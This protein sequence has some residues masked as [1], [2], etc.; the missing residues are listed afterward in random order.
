MAPR[1]GSCPRA[2]PTPPPDATSRLPVLLAGDIGGT[3]TR[4]ALYEETS[5]AREVERVGA[6]RVVGRDH[7]WDFLCLERR[8]GELGVGARG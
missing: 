6:A 7:R 4:L 1:S 3:K 8:L 5:G 2:T